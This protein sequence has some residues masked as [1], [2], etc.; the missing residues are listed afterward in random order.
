[1]ERKKIAVIGLGDFGKSLVRTLYDEGHE[2]LAIDQDMPTIEDISPDCT[3]A[4]C[5]DSRDERALRSQDLEDMDFV[6]LASAV[7]F[8]SLIV[9]ADNLKKIG[10]KNIF[11]RYKTDLHIRI[12]NMLGIHNTFNPEEQAAK[13]VAEKFSHAGIMESTYISE[14]YL[15]DEIL[16]PEVLIGVSLQDSHLREDYNLSLITIKRDIKRAREEWDDDK[17]EVIGNPG[18]DTVFEQGDVLVVFGSH[19]D[20][21]KFLDSHT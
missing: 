6:I 14:D 9:T 5:L 18:K 19:E 1:M 17:L 13:N 7:D 10:I 15:I 3:Q 4:V 21:D 16:V 20:I 12:L 11:A 8:E 2:V